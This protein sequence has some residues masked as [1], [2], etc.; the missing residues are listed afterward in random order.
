MRSGVS[1]LADQVS[2]FSRMPSNQR[3]LPCQSQQ[4]GEDSL[5]KFPSFCWFRGSGA[6]CRGAGAPQSEGEASQESEG[7][8]VSK[9][10]LLFFF[11]G[12]LVVDGVD[13]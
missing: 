7:E 13:W 12:C 1:P 4:N 11:F 3:I 8:V 6:C 5:L 10:E 2:M 9:A